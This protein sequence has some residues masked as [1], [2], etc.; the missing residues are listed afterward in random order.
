MAWLSRCAREPVARPASLMNHGEH[1][2]LVAA[3]SYAIE[4]RSPGTT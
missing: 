1:D 3:I 2:D 4:N